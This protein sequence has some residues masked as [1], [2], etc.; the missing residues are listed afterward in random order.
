MDKTSIIATAISAIVL[1]GLIWYNSKERTWSDGTRV[2]YKDEAEEN[3][4]NW[5]N[6]TRRKF[7][8]GGKRTKKHYK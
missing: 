1:G 5:A 8:N 3:I 4:L 2:I 6:E 7:K